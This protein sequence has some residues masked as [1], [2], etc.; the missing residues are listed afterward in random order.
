MTIGH[1]RVNA[2]QS[3][4]PGGRAPADPR[5]LAREIVQGAR[6]CDGLLVFA[7]FERML[8]LGAM[9][10][11]GAGLPLLVRGALVALASTPATGVV[12]NS[13]H[14]VCDLETDVNVPG[15]IYAGC[16]GLQVRGAGLTFCHPGA[17]RLRQMLPLL[18]QELSERLASLPG[19]DVES[20]E[21][22][23][24]VHV[25]R[26]DR[27]A[28]AVIVAHAEALRRTSAGEFSVWPSESRVD[29]FPDVE[30]RSGESALW[31]LVQWAHEGRGQPAVV[32]IGH[33]HTDEDAYRALPEHGYAVHVGP[34]AT[35][36]AASC[37]VADQAAAFDL[38]AQIA[39]A[40]SLRPAG[41]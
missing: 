27:S 38:L 3:G 10:G 22:G 23:I 18:A 24:T 7:D 21:L 15:L 20:R 17:A 35:E 12:V 26:P 25:R 34:P 14:D 1:R 13:G 28:I 11:R 29:L 19:V 9:N 40:W 36:S 37:W 16:R 33:D 6:S 39:F 31:I 41:R 5:E 30:W 2:E 4:C 8:C 32:Y